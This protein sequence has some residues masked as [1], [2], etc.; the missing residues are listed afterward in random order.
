LATIVIK[1][2]PGFDTESDLNRPGVFRVNIWVSKETFQALFGPDWK[3]GHDFSA[4]D[5]PFPHPVYG[6]Q[7]WVSFLNPGPTTSE[8]K[9]ELL[10]E[11]HERAIARQERRASRGLLTDRSPTCHTGPLPSEP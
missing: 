4:L 10:T 7:S 1:D 9:R 11:A 6:A 2:H 3:D 8:L 5:T